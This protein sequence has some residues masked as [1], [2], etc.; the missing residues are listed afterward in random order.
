[1]RAR[2]SKR[3]ESVGDGS[4]DLRKRNDELAAK[5]RSTEDA[6]TNYREREALIAETL[7]T[8]QSAAHA[9]REQVER[10][11]EQERADAEEL[12]RQAEQSRAELVSD[13]EWLRTMRTQMRD[14]IRSLLLNTLD[15]L[16][17]GARPEPTE[18]AP[19]GTVDLESLT[20][21]SAQRS[22]QN[23]TE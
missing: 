15:A 2:L 16:G 10:D 22:A 1:M 11:L 3:G 18:R 23:E 5:L 8:A 21:E 20:S 7:L 4:G 14:G 13:V 17:G 19:S 9:L 12:R 6:L